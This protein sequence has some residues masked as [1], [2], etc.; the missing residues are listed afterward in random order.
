MADA[1]CAPVRELVCREV[2]SA[3]AQT[4]VVLC[5][6]HCRPV[7]NS[8]SVPCQEAWPCEVGLSRNVRGRRDQ[9]CQHLTTAREGRAD[10]S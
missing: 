5:V 2:G 9:E 10:T 4:K 3:R 1:V 7:E 6:A 8:P